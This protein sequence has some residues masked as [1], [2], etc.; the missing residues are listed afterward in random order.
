MCNCAR[1]AKAA[2]SETSHLSKTGVRDD[3]PKGNGDSRD[4]NS[5]DGLTSVGVGI[6]DDLLLDISIH[7]FHYIFYFL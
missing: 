6:V 7:I 3:T 4:I 2:D 5:G 1:A